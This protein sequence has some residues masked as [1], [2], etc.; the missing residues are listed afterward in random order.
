MQTIYTISKYTDNQN[1]SST[2][3]KYNYTLKKYYIQNLFLH[4][5]VTLSFSD[6]QILAVHL[7]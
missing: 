7:N 3:R 4:P 1:A 2:M 5:S 6:Y